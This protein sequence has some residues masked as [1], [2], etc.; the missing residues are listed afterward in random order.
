MRR[1][2]R[3]EKLRIWP[4]SS[5]PDGNKA[6]DTISTL[7]FNDVRTTRKTKR[8]VIGPQHYNLCL[9]PVHKVGHCNSH[10]SINSRSL[11][12]GSDGWISD[13]GCIERDVVNSVVRVGYCKIAT[14]DNVSSVI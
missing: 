13:E 1:A 2:F 12:C 10:I 5:G 4:A 6:K 7:T 9:V 11:H 14:S 3:A 8:I